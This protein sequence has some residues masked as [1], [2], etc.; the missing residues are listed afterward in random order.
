ML[1]EIETFE[2]FF[3]Q[4]RDTSKIFPKFRFSKVLTN[5]AIFLNF[6]Q[7]RY[8]SK[9]L[10]SI[11]IFF[12]KMTKIKIL[13][14]LDHNRDVS[15]EIEVFRKLCS[16]FKFT[17]IVTKS[18]F[19]ENFVRNRYLRQFWP[20]SRYFENIHQNKDFQR[21]FRKILTKIAIFKIL[22]K[23]EIFRKWCILSRFFKN[24]D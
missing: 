6:G 20:N 4:N 13:G 14:N 15:T 19:F 10:T 16:N 8:I 5:I 7:N 23:I 2:F 22:A 21:F 12:K 17:R 11:M 18:L 3:Y 9:I 24:F 1:P